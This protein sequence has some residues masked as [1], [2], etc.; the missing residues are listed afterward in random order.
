ML[1]VAACGGSDDATPTT[2]APA[3]TGDT[4]TTQEI[5]TVALPCD[6]EPDPALF[7]EGQL[8]PLIPACTT[9]DELVVHLIREGTGRAAMA[10]DTLIVDYSGMI[11]GSGEL[12]DTSYTRGAPID[13]PLGRGGVIAGWDEG[14]VGAQAGSFL[15]L[16]IPTD[17]AYGDTPPGDQIQPGDSLTFNVEIRAVVPP[18]TAADAPLDLDVPPSIG[19]TELSITDLRVGDGALLELGD[20]AVVHMLLVRGDN[21]VVLY[22]TWERDDPLQI[23]MKEGDT[24]PGVFQGLQGAT[25]GSMRLL[26][27][28]PELA[29]GPDGE[30]SLGLPAG[31]DLIAIVEVVGAY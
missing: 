5:P 14:L 31:T 18:V 25:V 17:L 20:T 29:F 27:M 16:D 22:N 7:I 2:T 6:D 4:T 15:R 8:P 9:P 13:F 24:L 28:P 12:F 21:Q 23:V 10:G 3:A 26:T 19:A 1:A 30:P 11:I